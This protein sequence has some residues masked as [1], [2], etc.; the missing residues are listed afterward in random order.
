MARLTDPPATLEEANRQ[1]VDALE[2]LHDA[3]HD[4]ATLRDQLAQARAESERFRLLAIRRAAQVEAAR[5]R[6]ADLRR[7]LGQP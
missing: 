6:V 1:L 4:N 3:R 5:L 2:S 7:R